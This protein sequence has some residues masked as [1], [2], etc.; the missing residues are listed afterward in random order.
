MTHDELSPVEDLAPFEGTPRIY[1][2]VCTT[3]RCGG[4]YLCNLLSE[5]MVLG[6]PLEY[7]NPYVQLPRLFERFG[8]EDIEFVTDQLKSLRTTPNGVFGF[9]C[10]FDQFQQLGERVDLRSAF[11]RL[12]YIHV[13]RKDVLRQAISFY[14]AKASGIWS[15]YEDPGPRL[16]V[17]FDFSQ[18]ETAMNDLCRKNAGCIKYFA[19]SNADRLDI[20][21]ESLMKNPL[22][23][24]RKV[25]RFVGVDPAFQFQT[26]YTKPQRSHDPITEKWVRVIRRHEIRSVA[27]VCSDL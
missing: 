10:H 6:K 8:S 26:P 11:P 16:K 25:A 17:R 9:K 2:L 19:L 18:I 21:Y 22:A 3:P 12:R 7:Y 14:R 27:G 23:Q 20:S 5:T 4:S 13:Y 24:A 15:V 1:Y